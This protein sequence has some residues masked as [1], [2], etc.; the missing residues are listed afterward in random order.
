MAH[1]SGTEDCVLLLWRTEKKNREVEVDRERTP[2]QDIQVEK[3]MRP[4][5]SV[6]PD[7]T[8]REALKIM[9]DNNV[10]GVPVVGPDGRLEGFVNDG[11]LLESA[12][13]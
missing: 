12:L 10:P 11:H 9:R 4:A 3:I 8:A 1:G 7:T 5:V 2:R 13:P 6:E